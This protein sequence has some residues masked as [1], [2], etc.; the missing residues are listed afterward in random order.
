MSFPDGWL[1]EGFRREKK[2][3]LNVQGKKGMFGR[4]NNLFLQEIIRRKSEVYA[5]F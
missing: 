2:F 1:K 3:E 4:N 5:K